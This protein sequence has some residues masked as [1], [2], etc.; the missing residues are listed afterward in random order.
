[1]KIYYEFKNEYYGDDWEPF[2]SSHACLDFVAE[3]IAERFWSGDPSSPDCFKF[4][5]EVRREGNTE[6]KKFKVTAEADVNFHA[7][8]VE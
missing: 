4:E 7:W 2:Q 3:E 1:M 6:S 5:V 8:D